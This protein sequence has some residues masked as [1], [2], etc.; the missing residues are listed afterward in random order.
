MDIT[1]V[2]KTDKPKYPVKEDVSV[3][4]LKASI[5]KRWTL[6][7][8]ARVALGTLAVISLAGCAADLPTVGIPA[9][10]AAKT[11]EAS[12]WNQTN[13]PTIIFPQTVG[14]PEPSQI[15]VIE[16]TLIGEPAM[17]MIYVAPL[18]IHGEGRGAF[19]CVMV[20]PPVFLSEDDALSVINEISKE[21]GLNFSDKNSPEFSGVLQPAV[22]IND[23]EDTKTSDKMITLKADFADTGHGIAI[24][25]VS[26]DD[27]KA[28]HQGP[29]NLSV[30]QYNTKD[31]AAQLSEALETAINEENLS[32]TT[33]VMYD[34][35]EFSKE[36]EEKTRTLS[37]H[38]LKA[39]VKDFFEWLKNKGII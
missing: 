36:S 2:K 23:P 17:P 37:K 6:N 19:G 39:Q 33:G 21:Y 10:P 30:E 28:W 11:G 12:F 9:P 14:V 32:Y 20:A 15:P 24:E 38:Q 25:F 35:C 7:A 3:D 16:E 26:V 4:D 29:I 18:F 34:P 5:P 13:S 8:A 31:A 1:P 22:N 27:V